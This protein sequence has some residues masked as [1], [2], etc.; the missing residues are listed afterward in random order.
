M[1]YQ[2]EK[3]LISTRVEQS[4]VSYAAVAIA[5][6]LSKYPTLSRE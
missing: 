3:I 5:D 1:I 4:W 2:L 6:L